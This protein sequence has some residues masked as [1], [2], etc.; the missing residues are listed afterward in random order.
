M[1]SYNI[2]QLQSISL[3]LAR[4]IDAEYSFP[5]S[6]TDSFTKA[7]I[8]KKDSIDKFNIS[9]FVHLFSYL[10]PTKKA[11]DFLDELLVSVNL[12]STVS[13]RK[14]LH[15]FYINIEDGNYLILNHPFL[16]KM[17]QYEFCVLLS[18]I[19][20]RYQVSEELDRILV[21]YFK[22][23]LKSLYFKVNFKY[24][25]KIGLALSIP[26]NFK[27]E[28][29]DLLFEQLQKSYDYKH[30]EIYMYSVAAFIKN[31]HTIDYYHPLMD[32]IKENI[33]D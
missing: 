29:A 9:C 31:F 14:P 15:D 22:V 8:E 12:P 33:D 24:R 16:T 18:C 11:H 30:R 32:K 2:N 10:V 19:I 7:L 3:S 23:F 17:H 25:T 5:Y 20:Y 4:L 27:I 21:D 13:N 1:P 6:F 28:L 26:E